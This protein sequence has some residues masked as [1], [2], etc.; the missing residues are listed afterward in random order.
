M[1]DLEHQII[2]MKGIIKDLKESTDFRTKREEMVKEED[3]THSQRGKRLRNKAPTGVSKRQRVVKRGR[4]VGRA[5][6]GKR[7]DYDEGKWVEQEPEE[8][9]DETSSEPTNVR[10]PRT[11]RGNRLAR[12][13]PNKDVL[14]HVDENL[15]N[16]TEASKYRRI[17]LEHVSSRKFKDRCPGVK[18]DK[19]SEDFFET[20]SF[21]R[22]PRGAPP[23]GKT[24]NYRTGEWVD[25]FNDEAV[26]DEDYRET[27][28]MIL[29]SRASCHEK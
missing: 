27:Q 22:R 3:H 24:W 21:Y 20:P 10:N 5:P 19:D 29:Q 13:R 11:R 26:I 7:W 8:G 14:R 4:P 28:K 1:K 17:P 15:K 6:K 23:K 9:I 12:S 2:N 18:S 16:N 25:Y